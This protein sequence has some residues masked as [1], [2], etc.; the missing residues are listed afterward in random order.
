MDI[1]DHGGRKR[2]KTKTIK[3]KTKER[4]IFGSFPVQ[5]HIPPNANV[6]LHPQWEQ[7]KI[8]CT[9]SKLEQKIFRS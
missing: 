5:S 3:F 6:T 2:K 1:L 9:K 4:T 8:F 7:R